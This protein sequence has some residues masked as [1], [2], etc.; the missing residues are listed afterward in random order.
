ME[1]LPNEV[2]CKC[3]NVTLAD[4]DRVLYQ[5]ARF[6]DVEKEFEELQRLTNCSTGCG[7]CHDK[8]MKIVSQA[9]SG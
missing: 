8:I 9:V 6:T 3:K 2:I 4:I 5:S 1:Y 7:G